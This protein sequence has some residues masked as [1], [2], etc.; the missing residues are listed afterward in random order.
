M[1]DASELTPKKPNQHIETVVY[2]DQDDHGSD[3]DNEMYTNADMHDVFMVNQEQLDFL[4]D[5]SLGNHLSHKL[6]G[7]SIHPSD[8]SFNYDKKFL[9]KDPYIKSQL[10]NLNVISSTSDLDNIFSTSLID[11]ICCKRLE[12]NCNF[13]M[14]SVIRY[15]QNTI[16]QLKRISNGD[17]LTDRTKEKWREA[18]FDNAERENESKVLAKSPSI[19][20]HVERKFTGNSIWEDIVHSEVDVRSLSKILEKKIIVRIPKMICGTYRL[21]KQQRDD[22]LIISC[23]K[24]QQKTEKV[25]GSGVDV[26]I[27]LQRPQKR[28]VTSTISSIMILKTTPALPGKV[29]YYSNHQP[30]IGYKVVNKS[31]VTIRPLMLITVFPAVNFFETSSNTV[32]KS[33]NST[34]SDS[35]ESLRN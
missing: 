34:C 23:R 19:P 11:Y 7:V 32:V 28:Q 22:N 12:D 3:S 8:L 10:Q 26:V 6:G 4:T 24:E 1:N 14:D 21:Y 35:H 27:Q 9:F 25:E 30:F 33:A 2:N 13:Y 29:G 20:I 16:D 31:S 5:K 15:V 18:Y 17:Y